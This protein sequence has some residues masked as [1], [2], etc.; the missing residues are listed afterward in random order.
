MSA[1]LLQATTP[2]F[3][4]PWSLQ[5]YLYFD[6]NDVISV[7]PKSL[8]GVQLGEDPLLQRPYQMI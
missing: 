2:I 3:S 4:V 7:S 6:D 5:L 1:G 8:L